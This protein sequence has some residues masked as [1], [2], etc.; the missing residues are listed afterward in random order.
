MFTSVD[1]L[2]ANFLLNSED[3]VVLS[4]T[5]RSAGSTSLD[6]TSSETDNEISNESIFGFSG[7]VGDH[8]TE[9]CILGKKSSFNG[10]SD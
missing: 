1:S 9:A 2:V 3:L 4:K 5:L 10:F 8:D 6:L 7:S